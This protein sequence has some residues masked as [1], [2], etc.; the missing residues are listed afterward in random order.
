MQPLDHE[1]TAARARVGGL[2][3]AARPGLMPSPAMGSHQPD[4]LKFAVSGSH[5]YLTTT[6]CHPLVA[7]QN[8]PTTS[9]CASASHL[10]C[11]SLPLAVGGS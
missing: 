11:E 7:S 3:K 5:G 6:S 9:P 4:T 1:A 8:L 10:I 2:L